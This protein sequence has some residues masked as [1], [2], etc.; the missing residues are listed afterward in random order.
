MGGHLAVRGDKGTVL[1][2]CIDG[3]P[4]TH[5]L[6][7]WAGVV[8]RLGVKNRKRLS[9]EGDTFEKIDCAS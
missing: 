2:G 4:A 3:L 9:V 7:S 5:V 6:G 1:S 8:F